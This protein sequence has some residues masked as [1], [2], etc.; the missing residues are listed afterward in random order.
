MPSDSDTKQVLERFGKDHAKH[1]E[2]RLINDER[3]RIRDSDSSVFF[4]SQ[5]K[6]KQITA[7]QLLELKQSNLIMAKTIS[8]ER[9]EYK[10][11][12]ID[13]LDTQSMLI[14]SGKS[15]SFMSKKKEHYQK[16]VNDAILFGSS[17]ASSSESEYSDDETDECGTKQHDNEQK[18]CTFL[19][20]LFG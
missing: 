9:V 14:S 2:R 10:S 15:K 5:Q 19:R 16:L 18:C 20:F 12:K 7:A 3:K 1:L 13:V 4:G 17:S 11:D 6:R 8:P